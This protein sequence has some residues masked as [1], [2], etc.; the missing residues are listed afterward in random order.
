M[1]IS[2][3]NRDLN[4]EYNFKAEYE[5][6]KYEIKLIRNASKHGIE[7]FADDSNGMKI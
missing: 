2:I 5:D 1:Q 3:R 7:L 6:F 4:D